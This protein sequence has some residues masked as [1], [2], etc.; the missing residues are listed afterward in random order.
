LKQ[1][2]AIG[3]LMFLMANCLGMAWLAGIRPLQARPHAIASGPPQAASSSPSPV[4]VTVPYAGA[5]ALD[6]QAGFSL[7]VYAAQPDVS[8][9]YTRLLDHLVRLNVNSL[10]IVFPLYTDGVT[11]ST[12]HPG[13]DTPSEDGLATMVRM[14]RARHLGVMLRPI[15]D[16]ATLIPAWRGAI[17]PG[18]PAAWFAS[19]GSVVLSYARFAQREGVAS[20]A[21]GTEF[22]SMEPYLADWNNLISAV[23]H[24]FSGEI[25]YA[26]NFGASFQTG[27]WTSLDFVSM[28]A[29]F[30]LDHTPAVATAEQM[31]ADWQ[32]WLAML[33]G[34]DE[35]FNKP[36]VFTEVGV[37][38][39]TGA[40][41]RPWDSTVKRALDLEEQRAYYEATCETTASVVQGLYWWATGPNLPG[42]LPGELAVTDYNPLGRPAENVVRACYASIEGKV[43]PTV[44]QAVPR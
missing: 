27:F 28:D 23:R 6:F 16:E 38:P 11:A 29:Y 4:P 21:V 10:S 9:R 18:D 1:R 37:V 31:A 25:T 17:R 44:G 2:L 8:T 26:F 43:V 36:I 42:D 19:Y 14:A 12:V 22:N 30:P 3:G 41:L 5:P 15:L 32:R 40:H 39:E 33:R 24:V 7:L 35:P 13:A 20:L 34:I